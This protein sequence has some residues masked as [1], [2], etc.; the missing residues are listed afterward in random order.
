MPKAYCGDPASATAEEGQM[1]LERLSDFVIE[2]AESL[3]LERGA[4]IQR[5]LYGRQRHNK[6]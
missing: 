3:F 1:I 6:G 5:G 2:D 4:Q